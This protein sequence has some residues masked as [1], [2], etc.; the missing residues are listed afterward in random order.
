MKEL[1]HDKNPVSKR[2]LIRLLCSLMQLQEH[3]LE[4]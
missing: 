1:T 3:R 4:F 2:R